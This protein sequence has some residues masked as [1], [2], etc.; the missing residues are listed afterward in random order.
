[1]LLA[2][3]HCSAAFIRTMLH[4]ISLLN[5]TTAVFECIPDAIVTLVAQIKLY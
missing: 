1:M 2:F 4:I 5:E 3:V